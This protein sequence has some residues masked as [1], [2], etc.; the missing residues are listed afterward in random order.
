ML[1]DR[2]LP[3]N[4]TIPVGSRLSFVNR[5]THDHNVLDYGGTFASPTL[6]SG[7]SWTT[8]TF[9]RT[10]NYAFYCDLH[11]GMQGNLTVG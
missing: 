6:K 9:T 1:D 10:G 7:Q 4:V 11:A 5:G 8:L 3:P 2:F